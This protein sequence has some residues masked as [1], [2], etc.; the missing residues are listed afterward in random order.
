MSRSRR[1]LGGLWLGYMSQALMMLTGLWLT[2]FL[3]HRIGQ[4]DYGL[5]LVALQVLTY[6]TLIDLGVV[7]LLPRETAYATGRAGGI[8]AATDLTQS[9]GQTARIV[10]WQ[11]PIVVVAALGAYLLMPPQWSSLRQP[12]AWMLAGFV[13]TFPIRI[14]QA[15]LRGL[16]DLTFIGTVNITSFLTSTV[17]TILLVSAGFG[18]TSLALSWNAG[19]VLSAG[20]CFA[21]LKLRFPAVLPKKLPAAGWQTIRRQLISGFWVSVAQ[22]AQVMVNATDILIVG[23]ILGP[24]A[25]VVYS[26]TGKLISILA[27]QPQMLMQSA[28]PGLCEM[29]TGASRQRLLNALT[30]LTQI[31][32][33][34]SSG[35]IAAVLLVN[36]GFVSWWVGSNLYGGTL[37][38][39]LLL[40]SMFFRHLNT[41]YAHV[42]L[43]L[44]HER[45]LSLTNL[46]DGAVT[47]ASA[48][49]LTRLFGLIGA[50]IGSL[51]GVCLVSLP[52]NFQLV[53]HE[54]DSTILKVLQ[55]LS[56]L[57]SRS[58]AIWLVIF[59]VS[60]IWI[61]RG[62]QFLTIASVAILAAFAG[63]IL[64][65]VFQPPI[66]NY[67]LGALPPAIAKRFASASGIRQVE[68]KEREAVVV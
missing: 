20:M 7:A 60:A 27:N 66:R 64:P 65:F 13:L 59:F 16:Q 34:A 18:F 11:M 50:P 19:Q 57:L 67:L 25:V 37:L 3:L 68:D 40:A 35:I 36:S 63:L 56:P 10:L 62:F 54:T 29:I 6:L 28:G 31:I 48:I 30:S 44:G 51:M 49:V 61:P 14:F 12:F 39:V 58:F 41:S 24:S 1:F 26:C 2:P 42:V 47:I 15:V 45:R 52:A 22:V 17:V 55:P 5:W 33:M 9:I 4:H 8:T 43:F 53:S 46:A 21:R 23:R 32:L 38:N